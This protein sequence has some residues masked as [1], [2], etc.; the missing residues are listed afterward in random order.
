MFFGNISKNTHFFGLTVLSSHRRLFETYFVKNSKM[1]KIF[2]YFLNFRT[3]HIFF[4]FQGFFDFLTKN[5]V[6][7][8]IF[9][10]RLAKWKIFRRSWKSGKFS[11]LSEIFPQLRIFHWKNIFRCFQIGKFSTFSKCSN[12]SEFTGKISNFSN[13]SENW[14]FEKN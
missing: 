12:S 11:D 4:V 14:I 3:I 5:H 1:L 8:H 10:L 2:I 9:F 7:A 6:F 13:G